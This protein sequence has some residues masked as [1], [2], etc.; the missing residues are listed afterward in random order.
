MN[1]KEPVYQIQ[2]SLKHL[3]ILASCNTLLLLLTTYKENH[4]TKSKVN[5]EKC[6]TLKVTFI[7]QTQVIQI[8]PYT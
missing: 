3:T 8:I 4:I 6:Y 7:Y 5:S 2:G 1:Y